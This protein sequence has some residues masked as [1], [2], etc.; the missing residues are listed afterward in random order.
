M[1]TDVRVPYFRD[2]PHFRRFEGI[3]VRYL[4]FHLILATFVRRIRWTDE[5]TMQICH[6]VRKSLHFDV[7]LW[8]VV[9]ILNLFCNPPITIL[10]HPLAFL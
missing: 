6:V 2:E 8:I 7:T 1:T 5:I 10:R 4:D 3:L 9:D